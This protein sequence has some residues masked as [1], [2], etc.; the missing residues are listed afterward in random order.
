MMGDEKSFGEKL[1]DIKSMLEE[2][3]EKKKFRLSPLISLQKWKKN[4]KNFALI[5]YIKNNLHVEFKFVN[6]DDST[7]KINKYFHEASAKDIIYYKKYP[8]LIIKE[9]DQKPV[10]MRGELNKAVSDGT[11]TASEKFIITKMEMESVKPKMKFNFK[12]I[13]ILLLL[14]AGLVYGMNYLGVF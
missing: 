12:A 1:D 5:M 6:I 4:K 14:G 8:V 7:V 3:E 11:L 2:K 10:S 13:I 9:W